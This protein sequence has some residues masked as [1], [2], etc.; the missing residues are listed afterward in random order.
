[1]LKCGMLSC[2]MPGPH[3]PVVAN[4]AV[5][6]N[7]YNLLHGCAYHACIIETACHFLIAAMHV[8]DQL[9][10]VASRCPSKLCFSICLGLSQD[11]DLH[12]QAV[13]AKLLCCFKVSHAAVFAQTC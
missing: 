6:C 4:P 2:A 11:G 9:A 13:K 3:Q 12:V 1:M 7:A 8:F 5:K 10:E